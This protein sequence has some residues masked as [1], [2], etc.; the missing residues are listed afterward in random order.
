[1]ERN[2]GGNV[3]LKMNS[4]SNLIFDWADCAIIRASGRF[5]IENKTGTLVET[6]KRGKRERISVKPLIM[7]KQYTVGAPVSVPRPSSFASPPIRGSRA[8]NEHRCD[9]C[10]RAESR[11]TFDFSITLTN[12]SVQF[13]DKFSAIVFQFC[14]TL[15]KF[16]FSTRTL[17]AAQFLSQM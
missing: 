9:S 6:V 11:I 8:R 4:T 14:K 10:P 13:V 2:V 5:E 1:M 15:S 12:N 17:S 3:K 7:P 16:F